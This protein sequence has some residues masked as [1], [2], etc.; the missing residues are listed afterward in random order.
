MDEFPTQVVVEG[1]F[2]IES[3]GRM[4]APDGCYGDWWRYV[5]SQ[6]LDAQTAITGARSGTRLEVD[7][8]LADMVRGLNERLEKP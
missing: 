7:E 6:G 1:Q 4:A 2:Q 3:V 8:H 5:I